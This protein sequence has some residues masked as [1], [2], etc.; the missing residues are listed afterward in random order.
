LIGCVAI[1]PHYEAG[2]SIFMPAGRNEWHVRKDGL[3][4]RINR[5]R[6][7]CLAKGDDYLLRN[8]R[9]LSGKYVAISKRDRARS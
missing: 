4:S 8:S 3:I 5:S 1:L 9:S 7:G 2:T 6:N